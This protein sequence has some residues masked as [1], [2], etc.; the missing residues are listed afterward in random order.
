MFFDKNNGA[1]LIMTLE[2]PIEEYFKY[3]PPTTPERIALHDRVNRESLEICKAFIESKNDIEWLAIRGAA[4]LLAD[5]VCHDKTCN[6][7]AKS[8]I[9]EASKIA[10][11]YLNKDIKAEAILM[12]IQQ[13]RIFLNQGIVVDELKLNQSQ[14]KLSNDLVAASAF[15][16]T[17]IPV[18]LTTDGATSVRAALAI[19]KLEEI[20][21]T[22]NLTSI[23]INAEVINTSLDIL[24]D[25]TA[26]KGSV[27][28]EPKPGFKVNLESFSVVDSLRNEILLNPFAS[29]CKNFPI[30][31]CCGVPMEEAEQIDEIRLVKIKGGDGVCF[32]Y[33]LIAEDE[34]IQAHDVDPVS[35]LSKLWNQIDDEYD[36]PIN[37]AG[38][39][40]DY[41]QAM[42]NRKAGLEGIDLEIAFANE[43]TD[44]KPLYQGIHLTLDGDKWCAL[45]GE[46]LQVGIAGFGDDPI[47]ALS[48]LYVNIKGIEIDNIYG[49]ETTEDN[50][51]DSLCVRSVTKEIISTY[52]KS[53]LPVAETIEKHKTFIEAYGQALYNRDE[54]GLSDR[55]RLLAMGEWD[56]G[57]EQ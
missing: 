21:K 46:N 11:S 17:H 31:E 22:L 43:T 16:T 39:S 42:S 7:W 33:A 14:A 53:I 34:D 45:I 10:A 56:R 25:G 38:F 50:E 19:A 44:I 51:Q 12:H 23:D 24:A 1:R 35:A 27:I 29:N 49:S 48:D 18:K 36:Q 28:L 20:G 3:H 4:M 8:A 15:I 9:E 57:E 26:I 52:I 41:Q 30:P 5:E 54:D 55:E 37:F 2:L 6:D 40:Q 32:W 47:A 13:F